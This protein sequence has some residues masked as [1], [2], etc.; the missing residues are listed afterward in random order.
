MQWLLLRNSVQRPR[1]TAPLPSS[2]ALLLG[3]EGFRW[4]DLSGF[5]SAQHD[6][7]FD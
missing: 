3:Q 7:C 2:F 6:S 5:Y 4:S 1:A